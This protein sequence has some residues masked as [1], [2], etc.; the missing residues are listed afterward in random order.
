MLQFLVRFVVFNHLIFPR[1]RLGGSKEAQCLLEGRGIQRGAPLCWGPG[2][3][4]LGRLDAH[5]T[6]WNAI[7]GACPLCRRL[8]GNAKQPPM[9]YCPGSRW[10][11]CSVLPPERGDRMEYLVCFL[12]GAVLAYMWAVKK[13]TKQRGISLRLNP[14]RERP[15]ANAITNDHAAVCGQPTLLHS[16][17]CSPTETASCMDLSVPINPCIHLDT[18]LPLSPSCQ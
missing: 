11:L 9:P 8:P 6:L 3:G 5:F 2:V 1:R 4:I 13:R 12:L 18:G 17:E 15:P 7:R 14:F 10:R 16:S